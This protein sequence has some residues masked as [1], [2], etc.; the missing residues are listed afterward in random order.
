MFCYNKRFRNQ[1]S[2]SSSYV[3]S[4]E[5]VVG[6]ATGYWLDDRGVGVRV[7]VGSK[8]FAPPYRL[9]WLLVPTNLYV[10]TSFPVVNRPGLEGDHLPATSADVKKMWIYTYTP[11]Y[12]FMA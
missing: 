8:M 2:Y 4:R 12:A 7:P 5:S 9:D 1:N 6:I 3:R 10:G 11:P